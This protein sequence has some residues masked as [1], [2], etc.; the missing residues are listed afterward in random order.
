MCSGK[1]LAVLTSMLLFMIYAVWVTFDAL[2]PTTV[3][4]SYEPENS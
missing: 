1:C 2:Y 3:G 4:A